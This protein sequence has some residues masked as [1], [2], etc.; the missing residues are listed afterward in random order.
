MIIERKGGGGGGGGPGGGVDNPMTADLDTGGFKILANTINQDVILESYGANGSEVY[1]TDRIG[2]N[3]LQSGSNGIRLYKDIFAQSSAV[4]LGIISNP[5]GNVFISGQINNTV[6]DQVIEPGPAGSLIVRQNGGTPGADEVEISCDGTSGF[7]E[8]PNAIGGGLIIRTN[9]NSSPVIIGSNSGADN[10]RYLR[11]FN[12]FYPGSSNT[13]DLGRDFFAE[14]RD[15]FIGGR[16]RV[17][18]STASK[19]S[20]NIPH[21]VAPSAPVDGDMWTTSAGLFVQINGVTRSV[22]LT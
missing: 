17:G 18:A 7:I 9:N 14:W 8:T 19:S 10:V 6:G 2:G 13:T 15:L 1:L 5:F 20:L 12:A 4:D 21:G 22:N 11:A 16:A 3:T